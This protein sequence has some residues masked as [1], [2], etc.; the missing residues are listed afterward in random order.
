MFGWFSSSF[1]LSFFSGID[2]SL[3]QDIQSV[4]LV[5][6]DSEV[7]LNMLEYQLGWSPFFV[8][9]SKACPIRSKGL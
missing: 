6:S 7:V 4:C 8:K 5:S 2:S 9:V 3:S 1:Y